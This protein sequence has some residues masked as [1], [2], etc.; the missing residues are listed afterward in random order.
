MQ[1]KKY[2][3]I[4]SILSTYFKK[5]QFQGAV[6]VSQRGKII[7]QNAFGESNMEWGTQN[8]ITTKYQIGS[9]T[10]P[11]TAIMVL[12]AVE[13]GL[14]DLNGKITDYLTDFPKIQGDRITIHHLLSHTSG[15]IDFPDIQGFEWNLERLGHSQEM[16]LAYFKDEEL[17][18][19][20]GTEFRYS[21]LGYYLLTIILEN[22]KGLEFR[23]ILQTEIFDVAKMKNTSVS[24][25]RTILDQR[26]EGYANTGKEIINAPPWDQSIVKGSGD[27]ISTVGD[28]FLFD[29]SLFSEKL[30]SKEYMDILFAPTLPEKDNY[31]YGWF[32]S[33]PDKHPGAKWVRHSG[34]INGFSAML[35]HIIDN[36]SVI[37]L[38]ANLHGVNTMNITEEIK[39]ILFQ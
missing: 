8:T 7:Y 14:L 3:Q 32:V 6:L 21:N 39:R 2:S 20:P 31:A 23:E 10:K 25:F 37:I 13:D 22:V 12:K 30:L 36:D 5:G 27:M 16:M 19:E 4:D 34:S 24:G 9:V 38:L 18:F 35:T 17:K 11:F 33:L 28:L 29:R 15:L 1:E 26:A